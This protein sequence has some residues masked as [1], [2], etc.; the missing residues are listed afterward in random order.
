[1]ADI[2]VIG[3]GS[4]TI[5][6][7]SSIGTNVRAIFS[8]PTRIILGDYVSIGD[9]TKFIIENG[10]VTIDDWSTLHNDCSLFSKRGVI[11]G[12]HC[13]FGQS[14]VIDGTGGMTIRNGVRVGM[15]SQLWSH[16]AAGEQIE[17][18]TL[19]AET[20]TV[21][22][23]D[24]WLVGTCFVASGVTVGRRTVALSGSNVT[25]SCEANSVIAGAPAR[26]REGVNFYKPITLREKMALLA[27]WLEDFCVLYNLPRGSLTVTDAAIALDAGSDGRIVFHRDDGAVFEGDGRTTHC[28]LTSK[29]YLK[30]FTPIE[31]KV[32]KFLSGNKAR[33]YRAQ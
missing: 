1:M 28:C 31:H 16:V 18:C 6:K 3:P 33:F 17:G 13:W 11:I 8:A 12:Q 23:E 30:A 4:V 21:L 10:D 7:G 9:N 22:E 27:G 26:V 5:G 29:R 2:D 32:L 24:V 20:P 19:F 15:Y 25:K 14:C